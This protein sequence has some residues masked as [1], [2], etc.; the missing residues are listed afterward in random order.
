MSR[1]TAFNGET[2]PRHTILY[3]DSQCLPP[4][5][6][7][8]LCAKHEYPVTGKS[9]ISHA[10]AYSSGWR[11]RKGRKRSMNSS[12]GVVQH[13]L[14]ASFLPR[15]WLFSLT[16][17]LW[18]TTWDCFSPFLMSDI[19][20]RTTRNGLFGLLQFVVDYVCIWDHAIENL[21]LRPSLEVLN[22]TKQPPGR[23]WF[24]A[25]CVFMCTVCVSFPSRC[26]AKIKSFTYKLRTVSTKASE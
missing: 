20:D 10:F 8:I 15:G 21:D 13:F 23:S 12:R 18:G 7:K 2:T 22:S 11:R 19:C 9:F 26:V 25:V 3:S 4:G 6:P 14:R 24:A 16:R 5:D 1:D 17:S